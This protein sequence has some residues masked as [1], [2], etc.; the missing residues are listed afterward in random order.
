MAL[1]SGPSFHRVIYPYF[2]ESPELS[3]EAAR[4]GLWAMSMALSR[5]N[6]A[7]LRVLDIMTGASFSLADV[8][9]QGD[10]REL[11]VGKFRK[12]LE[13]YDALASD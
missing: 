6:P 2:A 13:D 4:L 5:Y 11:F 9:L 8:P 3:A 1:E 10:E 7:D 12:L